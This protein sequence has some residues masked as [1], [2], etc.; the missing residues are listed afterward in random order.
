MTIVK[1]KGVYMT[2]ANKKRFDKLG[3]PF[4]LMCLPYELRHEI[5]SYVCNSGRMKVFLRG[6]YGMP[7]TAIPLPVIARAGSRQLRTEVILISLKQAILEVH[8]GPGNAKLQEWLAKVDL[9]ASGNTSLKSGFDAVH[10]LFF[11]YFSRFP[12]RTLS[13]TNPNNDL[14]LMAKCRNLR[15]VTLDFVNSELIDSYGQS[16]SIKQLRSEYRL[17]S[18]LSIFKY[19][20]LRKVVLY[21][22]SYYPPVQETL[23]KLASWLRGE[24]AVRSNMETEG[25]KTSARSLEVVVY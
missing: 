15:K 4:P 22:L 17:D 9:S 6:I 16:K 11:P 2:E 3:K 18:M 13:A 8:S 10:Q 25:K 21:R 5:L 1:R 24:Y 7:R 23:K 19:G 14:L 20:E 12:H